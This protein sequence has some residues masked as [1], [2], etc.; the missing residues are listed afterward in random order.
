MA[1]LTL[2]AEGKP[3]DLTF[4]TKPIAVALTIGNDAVLTT[5]SLA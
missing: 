2:A 4:L 1:V 5:A 3:V